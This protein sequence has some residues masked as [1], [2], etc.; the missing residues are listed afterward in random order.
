[1]YEAIKPGR[2]KMTAIMKLSK[3]SGIKGSAVSC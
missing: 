3:P 2:R 1:M